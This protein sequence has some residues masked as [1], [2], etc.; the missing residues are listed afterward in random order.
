MPTSSRG[1]AMASCLP[2]KMRETI[3]QVHDEG[4]LFLWWDTLDTER[5]K[6]FFIKEGVGLV[7]ADNLRILYDLLEER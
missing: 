7:G 4:K 3:Q 2:T 5:L 1:R 6:R